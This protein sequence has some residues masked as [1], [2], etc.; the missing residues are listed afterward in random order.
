MLEPTDA[1]QAKVL[2]LYNTKAI[3][4]VRFLWDGTNGMDVGVRVKDFSTDNKPDDFEDVAIEFE[5]VTGTSVAVGAGPI[6]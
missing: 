4:T 2:D 5:R 1:G 6:L 3:G